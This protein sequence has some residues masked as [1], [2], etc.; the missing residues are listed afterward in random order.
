MSTCIDGSESC[1]PGD[2]TGTD[3]NCNGLDEDCDG[4]VDDG[5]VPTTCGVGKCQRQSSCLGGVEQIDL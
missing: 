1:T 4:L 5:Y 3:E 2:P